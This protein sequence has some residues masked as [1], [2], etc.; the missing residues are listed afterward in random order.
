MGLKI[1]SLEVE[2]LYLGTT[3][4][5]AL[6]LGTLPVEFGGEGN[7]DVTGYEYTLD[8][9]VATLTKYVGE[10]VDIVVPNIEE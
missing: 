6:Y 9:G 3:P 7:L 2:K 10:A 5:T 1:G 4:I 8:N